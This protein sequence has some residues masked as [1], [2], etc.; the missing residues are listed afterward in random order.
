MTT[1]CTYMT[2]VLDMRSR[3]VAC[4]L[5]NISLNVGRLM[6]LD[7]KH[8][9]IHGGTLLLFP[10]FITELCK[11]FK[12]EEY[13][14]DTWV[15]PNTLIYPLKIWGEGLSSKSKKTKINVDNSTYEDTNSSRTSKAG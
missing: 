9:K 15:Q 12:V 13:P 2:T 14:R 5:E 1:P 6:I 4:I 10:S 11:R 8:F 3:M 7:I